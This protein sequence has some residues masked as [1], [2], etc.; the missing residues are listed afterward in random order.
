MRE[1]GAPLV[2]AKRRDG[3]SGGSPRWK[4]SAFVA[5]LVVFAAA[6]QARPRD[7]TIADARMLGRMEEGEVDGFKGS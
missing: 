1:A 7:R 5:L 4:R 3:A 6:A 2:G